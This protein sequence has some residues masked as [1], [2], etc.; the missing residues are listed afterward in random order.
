[1]KKIYLLAAALMLT[2]AANAQD[3]V[4]VVFGVDMN[5][6]ETV[7]PDGV[8]I[9]GEI[10]SAYAGTACGNWSPGCTMLTDDDGD[11]VWTVK[12]RLPASTFLYKYV[13]GVAWGNN[14]GQ[15]LADCGVDDGNGGF[16]RTLD[17]TNAP[18]DRDTV[19]AFKYDS[20]SAPTVQVTSIESAFANTVNM[21]VAPNPAT[22]V[23]MVS[24]ANAR[25]ES[26]RFTMTDLTGKL[27]RSEMT[28]GAELTVSRN[29][30]PAGLYFVT[31]TNRSGEVATRKVMLR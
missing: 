17:L 26:Y 10:Q 25:S 24:F 5:H 9:A 21:E 16:N 2:F 28:N 20:C 29:D 18:L 3:S 1:M 31:L 14:E 15:G 22:D 30:L 23:F 7:S 6:V 12:L 8:S 11:G 4:N 19:V 27:V 13:N